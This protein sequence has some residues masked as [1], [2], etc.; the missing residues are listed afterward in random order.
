MKVYQ[1]ADCSGSIVVFEIDGVSVDGFEK[2]TDA[3]KFRDQ[4]IAEK[5]VGFFVVRGEDHPLGKS[6]RCHREFLKKE[7]RNNE[8][9][10]VS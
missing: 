3:K 4:A 9:V 5:N 10:R 8:I 2:K 1:V 6:E 7:I